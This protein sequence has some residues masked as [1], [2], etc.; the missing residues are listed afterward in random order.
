[1]FREL[2]L[3]EEAGLT[4]LEVLR[5][6]TT[7]GAKALRMEGQ[8]GAIAQGQLANLV[9][10]DGDPLADLGN[11]SRAAWVVRDGRAARPQALLA[12]WR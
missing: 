10:L 12:P 4:R 1:M 2:A 6:A 3:M 11:L 9:I 8:V 7:H 5:A